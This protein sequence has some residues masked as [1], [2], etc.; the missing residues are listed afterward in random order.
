MRDLMEELHRRFFWSPQMYQGSLA[1]IDHIVRTFPDVETSLGNI[2]NLQI[3]RQLVAR[4]SGQ[5]YIVTNSFQ[6]AV[7]AVFDEFLEIDDYLQSYF[8]NYNAEGVLN[9]R[10]A[11]FRERF[12]MG[13]PRLFQIV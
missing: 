11:L 2:A 7:E 13:E 3:K 1:V 5:R 8:E 12:G 6:A 4:V 10:I 9:Q